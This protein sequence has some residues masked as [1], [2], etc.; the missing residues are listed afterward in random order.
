ML[1]EQTLMRDLMKERREQLGLNQGE[2][3][4]R[5][6][7]AGMDITRMAISAWESGRNST[8]LDAIPQ[9]RILADVL[10]IEISD[11]FRLTDAQVNSEALSP[12]ASR[13]ALIV[14]SLTPDTQ[15]MILEMVKAVQ[16]RDE[17]HRKDRA[18]RQAK[19]SEKES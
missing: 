19:L 4:K 8:P 18:E 14:D 6:N 15:E 1:K 17:Q 2:L 9:I 11:L 3:A 13:I 10:E 16:V 7:D 5:L 12:V